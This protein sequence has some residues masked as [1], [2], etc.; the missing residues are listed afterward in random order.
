M[1]T[2]CWTCLGSSGDSFGKGWFGNALDLMFEGGPL[3]SAMVFWQCFRPHVWR[4]AF[5]VCNGLDTFFM[6]TLSPLLRFNQV[7]HLLTAPNYYSWSICEF[8]QYLHTNCSL[9]NKFQ[10]Y[11]LHEVIKLWILAD[12]FHVSRQAVCSQPNAGFLKRKSLE[13]DN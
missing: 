8:L 6:L 4:G 10:P 1:A 7:I 9:C 3:L 11:R 2:S 5:V 13:V 12:L